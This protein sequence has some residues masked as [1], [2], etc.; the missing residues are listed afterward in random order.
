MHTVK[1]RGIRRIAY[2][3]EERTLDV[4]FSSSKLYRYLDVP[5]AA[6]EWLSRAK[7]KGRFINRLIKDKYRCERVDGP[8]AGAEE[9]DLLDTLR[10]SLERPKGES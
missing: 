4:E 2:N 1:S 10:K 5:P 8:A 7:S 6:Y 3:A 9:P